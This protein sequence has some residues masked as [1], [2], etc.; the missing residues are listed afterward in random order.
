MRNT[1]DAKIEEITADSPAAKAGFKAGD[2]ITKFDGK[3]IK[4]YEE[5]VDLLN[6]KKPNDEVAVEVKRGDKM[7]IL[8]V[9][10]GKR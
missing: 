2:V 1:K 7:E 10:L 5:F 6:K 4:T 3:A 8:K 9:K